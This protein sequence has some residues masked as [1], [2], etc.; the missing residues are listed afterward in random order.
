MEQALSF[1]LPA[2]KGVKSQAGRFQRTFRLGVDG[3]ERIGTAT[4]H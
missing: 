3:V 1:N 4:Y 2:A